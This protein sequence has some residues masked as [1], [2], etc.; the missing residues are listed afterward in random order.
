LLQITGGEYPSAR[1]NPPAANDA[2]DLV[3]SRGFRAVNG[4][5]QKS[6]GTA[7]A[8]DTEP[9]V[10]QACAYVKRATR[11]FTTLTPRA[12]SS[13]KTAGLPMPPSQLS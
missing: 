8:D 5:K 3:S 11:Q 7:P 12:T 13:A 6:S 1:E 10:I 2:F 4:Y 9:R